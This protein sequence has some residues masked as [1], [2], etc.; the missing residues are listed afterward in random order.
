MAEDLAIVL[1]ARTL[2][3]DL[4]HG[5]GSDTKSQALWKRRLELAGK[6]D[7]IIDVATLVVAMRWTVE[8]ALQTGVW[9]LGWL[10]ATHLL[11]SVM[12]TFSATRAADFQRTSPSSFLNAMLVMRLS[13]WVAGVEHTKHMYFGI[14]F[15]PILVVVVLAFCLFSAFVWYTG[16]VVIDGVMVFEAVRAGGAWTGTAHLWVVCGAAAVVA[17]LR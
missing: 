1:T 17:A 8:L 10:V 16:V 13:E 9:T 6:V 2:G 12:G 14:Y 3:R 11:Q 4:C 5:V 7:S 15:L